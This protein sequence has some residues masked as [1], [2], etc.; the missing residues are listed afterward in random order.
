MSERG[1]MTENDVNYWCHGTN[2][3]PLPHVW[4]YLGRVA[5]AY[6]CTVCQLRVSK[7][8]LKANTDA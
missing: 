3:N 1:E 5:Q 7:G 4:R 8:E 2:S 6:Q